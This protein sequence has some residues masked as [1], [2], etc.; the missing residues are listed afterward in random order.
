MYKDNL[1]FKYLRIYL[2]YSE[3]NKEAIAI[4][5]ENPDAAFKFLKVDIDRAGKTIDDYRY[6][7]SC[8]AREGQVAVATT[9]SVNEPIEGD[10]V[11]D[12]EYPQ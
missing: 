5:A 2:F 12:S 4:C 10:Y 11:P 9:I 7:S 1:L 6:M 8:Y 3:T